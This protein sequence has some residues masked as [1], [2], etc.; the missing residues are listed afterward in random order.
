VISVWNVWEAE[1]EKLREAASV[2]KLADYRA[3][4]E[5]EEQR[6]NEIKNSIR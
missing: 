1:A 2:Q 6:R 5:A 3:A 4:Q